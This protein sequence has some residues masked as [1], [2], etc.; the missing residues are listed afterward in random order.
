MSIS[1]YPGHMHK[2]R[3]ALVRLLREVIA[4]IEVLDARAP[5]ATANPML[6][7]A[8]GNKPRIKVLC[9]ADLANPQATAK[10]Q[11]YLNTQPNTACL[12]SEFKN[13]TIKEKLLQEARHV[14]GRNNEN[15]ETKHE[16][17]IIGIPNVGKSTLLNKL[18]KR[19]L[20]KTGNEPALTRTQLRINL[21]DIWY[22]IDTPGMMWP[23]LEDQDGARMLAMLGSIR[24][25]A[26][27]VEEISWFASELLLKYFRKP[28]AERYKLPEDVVSPN[29][30]LLYIAQTRSGLDKGGKPDFHK[31]SEALLNDIRSGKLG[32][33][34]LEHAPD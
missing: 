28:L 10:W 33:L 22:V 16:L 18:A 9:K 30:L 29:Q 21:D 8:C 20:A 13:S 26:Y 34:S 15:K 27:E 1:W 14:I 11:E 7:E 3:K 25:T 17:A 24:N 4:V 6:A 12:I 5:N 19:K 2:N 23:K 32:P 31:A